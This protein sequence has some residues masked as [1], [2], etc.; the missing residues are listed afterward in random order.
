M[1]SGSDVQ[2]ITQVVFI[3]SRTPDI[4]ALIAGVKP[5]ELVFVL[6]SST[7]GVQQIA[8][9]LATNHLTG[10]AAISIVGHGASGEIQLGSSWLDESDLAAH[11]A[12]LSTI[13]AALTADGD[14]A[15]YACNTASGAAGQQFIADLSAYAGADVA[16]ATHLV[17]SADGGGSWTLD[18]STGAIE[19]SAPFTA[20][21]LANFQGELAINGQLFITTTGNGGGNVNPTNMALA[22]A[23]NRVMAVNS[24]GTGTT[25]VFHDTLV[26]TQAAPIQAPDDLVLDPASGL[27]FMLARDPSL[28]GNNRAAV[29]VGKMDGSAPAVFYQNPDTSSIGTSL[30]SRSMPA[31]IPCMSASTPT[32]TTASRPITASSASP[33]IPSPARS[34]TSSRSYRCSR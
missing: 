18:A 26:G 6:D 28:T 34:A 7:D 30:Q 2:T 22:A 3:D 25:T 14:L 31:P 29:L 11:A 15:L 13:G 19:A 27:Y 1:M 16:A 32:T 12:A 9:I 5:G 10:L 24:D 17:G 20:A 8:D 21:T 23:D 4:Q 33:M